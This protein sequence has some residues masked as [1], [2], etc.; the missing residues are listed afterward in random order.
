MHKKYLIEMSQ[1]KFF[2]SILLFSL[3]LKRKNEKALEKKEIKKKS[4]NVESIKSDSSRT[5][6]ADV[7]LERITFVA[8]SRDDD[9]H[10]VCVQHAY[11]RGTSTET[12]RQI[13]IYIHVL[14]IH[15]FVYVY[16]HSYFFFEILLF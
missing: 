9:K 8:I 7:V 11:Y 15:I 4:R 5:N 14:Y 16:I 13:S 1:K 10:A 3:S 2:T 6:I 12:V